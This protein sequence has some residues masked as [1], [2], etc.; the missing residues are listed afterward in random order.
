[1]LGLKKRIFPGE[2]LCRPPVELVPSALQEGVVDR[3][4]DE[5]MSEQEFLTLASDQGMLDE[6]L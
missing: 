4:A 3:V 5:R 6:L 1:M 2:P